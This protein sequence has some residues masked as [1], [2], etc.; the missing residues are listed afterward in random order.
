MQIDGASV[1]WAVDLETSAFPYHADQVI[2]WSA[3]QNLL[4]NEGL[5]L[6]PLTFYR[7]P[8][9]WA[10]SASRDIKGGAGLQ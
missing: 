9:R 8:L 2:G 5:P 4:S 3:V 1:G 6:V 10:R 7:L